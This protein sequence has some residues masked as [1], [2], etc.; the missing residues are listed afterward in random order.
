MGDDIRNE[1]SGTAHTVVQAGSIERLTMAGP[2]APPPEALAGLPPA[3][4]AFTGRR[5][6]LQEL[7]AGLKPKSGPRGRRGRGPARSTVRAWAGQKNAIALSGPAGVGKTALVLHAGH[8]ARARRWYGAELYL[9]LRGYERRPDDRVSAYDALGSFLRALR[10]AQR[11]IDGRSVGERHRLYRSEMRALAERGRPVLVV[12]D[13][14]ASIEQVTLL[15]PPHPRNCCVVVGRHILAGGVLSGVRQHQLDVLPQD[16]AVAFLAASLG[17]ADPADLRVSGHRRDALRLAELCDRLP[18]AL[19]VVAARLVT[20][21]GLPVGELADRLRDEARRLDALRAPDAAPAPSSAVRSAFALSYERLPAAEA[22]LFRLLSLHPGPHLSADTVAAL[23]GEPVAE[24]EPRLEELRRAHMITEGRARTYR[25][26]SLVRLY[27]AERAAAQEPAA[28]RHDA[29]GRLVA[30][31]ADRAGE[32]DAWLRPSSE[33][34]QRL[35]SGAERS[36]LTSRPVALSWLVTERL[37]LIAAV[38]LAHAS[39]HDAAVTALTLRLTAFFDLYKFWDDW[40]DTH[41]LAAE[42]AHRSG[43]PAAEAEALLRIGTAHRQ[44]A[45]RAP[46]LEAYTQARRLWTELGDER[47]VAEVWGEALRVLQQCEDDLASQARPVDRAA[48]EAYERTVESFADGADEAGGFECAARAAVLSNLGNLYA[49][50]AVAD[51]T[52]ALR[53]HQRALALRERGGDLRGQAQSLANL[54]H[55]HYQRNDQDDLAAATRSYERALGLFQ[56]ADDAHG[57][58]WTAYNLGLVALKARS[59]RR[60]GPGGLRP[61]RRARRHWR[62]AVRLLESHGLG[63]EAHRIRIGLDRL[64]PG[65]GRRTRIAGLVRSA[66]HTFGVALTAVVV[67]G[68]LLP[69]APDRSAVEHHP[70]DFLSDLGLPAD[71]GIAGL[72]ADVIED[73]GDPVPDFGVD[74]V[75]DGDAAPDPS[76]GGGGGGG[77]GGEGGGGGDH[78][79]GGGG[80]DHHGGGGGGDHHGGGGG[81]GGGDHHSSGG[82]GHD[83]DDHGH[84]GHWD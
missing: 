54:G 57:E 28:A 36:L 10:V 38:R 32:A 26:H 62:R 72:V 82:G 20:T 44:Q 35:H 64:R 9:D 45:R 23:T 63:A 1:F 65:Q 77:S 33:H 47:R 2:P 70:T 25:L 19:D 50:D 31:Y 16:E 61:V 53:C 67:G 71:S 15:L 24:V 55:V 3:P 42:A 48:V 60:G 14:A 30:H 43:D 4:G 80:G 81:G 17:A 8:T 41:R 76:G 39:G 75:N 83:H 6:P 68:E 79:G 74:Y 7:L 5:E 29:I 11:D 52:A 21:P 13:N 66:G 12:L 18:L 27:A 58:A 69:D 40:L 73:F 49:D 59:A 78:H 46:A 84:G 56:E 37:C 51:F 22:R 34:G